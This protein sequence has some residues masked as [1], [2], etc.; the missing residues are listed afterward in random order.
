MNNTELLNAISDMM[1]Q[2]LEDT[3]IPRVKNLEDT[4]IP[5]V[6][7][8]EDSLIPRVKNLEDT[9]IPRVKN[10]E[11]TLENELIPRVAHIEECYIDTYERYQKG[12]DQLNQMQMD[13]DVIKTTVI[14]HSKEINKI[15][16]PYLVK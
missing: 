12:I 3:L 10:L 2:K 5:R 1:D 14:G 13:I 11:L 16:G 7:N 4:L 9:L 8:L 6:K 15:T